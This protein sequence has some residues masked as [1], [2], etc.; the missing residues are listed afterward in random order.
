MWEIFFAGWHTEHLWRCCNNVCAQH[1]SGTRRDSNNTLDGARPRPMNEERSLTGVPLN[2]HDT[3]RSRIPLRLAGNPLIPELKNQCRRRC[4]RLSSS[5][6]DF[7]PLITNLKS[8]SSREL[9]LCSCF[10][11]VLLHHH[12]HLLLCILLFVYVWIDPS[13]FLVCQNT[14]KLSSFSVNLVL[15]VCGFPS[16][17]GLGCCWVVGG[18]F[19]LS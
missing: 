15:V 16:V 4:R 5:P 1:R 6:L 3:E 9:F 17:E 7:F 14:L 18:F 8:F 2:E 13:I 10:N 12:H 19:C 11:R